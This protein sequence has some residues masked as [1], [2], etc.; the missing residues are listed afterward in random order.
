[1]AT[2]AW[3]GDVNGNSLIPYWY[4][5]RELSDPRQSAWSGAAIIDSRASSSTV[6][7]NGAISVV[8]HI[9]SSLN[10]TRRNSEAGH[11]V[12]AL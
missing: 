10:Q 7:A 12:D 5:P 4:C 9:Q 11:T 3:H 8:P 6:G 1:M 2:G